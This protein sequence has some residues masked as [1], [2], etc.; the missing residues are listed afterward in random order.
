MKGTKLRM[1]CWLTIP[2]YTDTANPKA[3]YV[4]QKRVEG[5]R[6]HKASRPWVK[7]AC[8][9]DTAQVAVVREP[10]ADSSGSARNRP[11]QGELCSKKVGC[12][13][14]SAPHMP[15]EAAIRAKSRYE[16]S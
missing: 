16:S 9:V 13:Y 6:R 8:A 12:G 15:A 5:I 1:Q 14:P 11:N 4:S 10:D 7:R 2:D 3:P